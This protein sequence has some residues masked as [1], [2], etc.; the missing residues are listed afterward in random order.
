MVSRE[1]VRRRDPMTGARDT[2]A[3]RLGQHL[4]RKL[5]E[6]SPGFVPYTHANVAALR[7]V[8]QPGD[9]LLVE[10]NTRVSVAIK[11]LTSR[12]GRTRRSTSATRSARSTPTA[13]R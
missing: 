1:G 2:L 4:A 10:G 5:D 7:R 12:P 9:V 6:P 3:D 8:L 11:Y 13:S